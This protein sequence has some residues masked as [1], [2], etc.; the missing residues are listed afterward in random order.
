M[1][2]AGGYSV[3]AIAL[4]VFTQVRGLEGFLLAAGLSALGISMAQ[5]ALM[6]LAMDRAAPGRMGKSMATYSMFFRLG[7]GLGAPL[8]VSVALKLRALP[9]D[10]CPLCRDRAPLVDALD[11]N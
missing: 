6:A 2:I 5:P 7:E 1:W 11:I 3:L 8:A 10:Q 4:V 9:A